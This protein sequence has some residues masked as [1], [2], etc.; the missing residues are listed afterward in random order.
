MKKPLIAIALALFLFSCDSDIVDMSLPKT[1]TMLY[2][3]GN[4]VTFPKGTKAI[5]VYNTVISIFISH[6]I[7]FL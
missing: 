2:I 4:T 7:H 6:I 3:S 5:D 1:D